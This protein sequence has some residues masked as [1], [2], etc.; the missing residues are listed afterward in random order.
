M[1]AGVIIKG[2][3]QSPE[4]VVRVGRIKVVI[5]VCHWSVAVV[6]AVKWPMDGAIENIR[7]ESWRELR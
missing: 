6:V 7:R 2:G 1:V 3:Y 4:L 5:E